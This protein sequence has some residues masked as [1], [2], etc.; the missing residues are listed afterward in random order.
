MTILYCR[1]SCYRKRTSLIFLFIFLFSFSSLSGKIIESCDLT[2]LFE[3]ESQL[4]TQDLVLFDVDH[5]LILETDMLLRPCR[6]NSLDRLLAFFGENDPVQRKKL[7]SIIFLQKKV[8]LLDLKS[9]SLIENLLKRKV[10]VMALTAMKTGPLGIIDNIENYRIKELKSLG[11]DFREAFPYLPAIYF[12]DPSH[13]QSPPLFESGVL[14]SSYINKGEVL[15][16]FLEN[17]NFYPRQVVFVDN[18]YKYLQSVENELNKLGIPFLG[19]HYKKWLGLSKN[20]DEEI[21]RFQLLYLIENEH[22]L[23][24]L[25]AKS[26]LESQREKTAIYTISVK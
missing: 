10:K 1:N 8:G 3:I 18:S 5:T 22:W 2:P 14:F 15:R 4:S 21:A 17:I 20:F 16:D 7:I 24:D 25:E 13:P 6:R 11:I 23:D 12:E 19:I 9:P 26:I